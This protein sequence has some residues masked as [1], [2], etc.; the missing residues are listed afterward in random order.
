M[1]KVSTDVANGMLTVIIGRVDPLKIREH[2][3]S[4]TRKNVD[5]ISPTVPPEEDSA[6][7]PP[8]DSAPK[9]AKSKETE[10][11]KD[12]VIELAPLAVEV[13]NMEYYGVLWKKRI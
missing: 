12:V 8:E 10:R 2:V 13:N 9:D 6:S 4:E 3:E 11:E 5:L 7:I 1:R